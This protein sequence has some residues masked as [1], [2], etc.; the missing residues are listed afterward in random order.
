M[1]F[2]WLSVALLV[3]LTKIGDAH[4]AQFTTLQVK[5]DSDGHFHASLNIDILSFALGKTSQET[6]NEELEALLNGPRD[7]LGSCLSDAGRNFRGEVVI[8]TNTGNATITDWTLPT[9]N[10]VE[11]VLA[12]KLNPRI[13][14]P[15]EIDFSG[16]LPPNA[17]SVQIRLPYVLGQ[18]EQILELSNGTTRDEPV[19]AGDYSSKVE[20]QL[21]PDSTQKL[22]AFGRYIIVGFHHII[23]E[24]TDHILFVLGLFLLSTRL[25]PL[26]WQVSAFTVAHSIT[27]GLS[28]YGIIR[29]SPS[30][31]E[32]L[33]AA[34]IVFVAVENLFTNDMQPWRPFVV[35]GFGLIHGLGFASAFAETGLPREHFLLGLIGFNVGVECGQLTVIACALLTVGWFRKKP[36]YRQRI[37]VPGSIIIAVIASFWTV[38]RIFISAN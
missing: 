1:R 28:I 36:W 13:L 5:V 10:D 22:Y 15:G 23:P 31:T 14:M 30:I 12:R 32:P 27:L 26:F 2:A 8:R 19:L 37:V 38:Q 17:N 11:S 6:S 24:G 3:L 33:I 9:L 35:F 29:L 25:L 34:S 4:P 18:T 20:I 16:T 7:H 21:T